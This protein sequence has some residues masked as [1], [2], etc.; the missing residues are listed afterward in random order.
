MKI[1]LLFLCSTFLF[2]QSR[3]NGTLQFKR[4]DFAGQ[5]FSRPWPVG[6]VLPVAC[7][8][9]ES[10]FVDNQQIGT[11]LYI[12]RQANVWSEV[13]E[14]SS[15]SGGTVGQAFD[16]GDFAVQKISE[17]EIR[18]GSSCSIEKPCRARF[19]SKVVTLSNFAQV[20][21]SGTLGTGKLYIWLDGTGLRVGHNTQA[22]VI[23]NSSCAVGSNVTDFP[24]SG[25]PLAEIPFTLN[26]F[27]SITPDTDRRAFLGTPALEAGASGNLLVLQNSSTGIAAVDLNPNIDFG[28]LVSTRPTRRGVASQIPA[29]CS[30]GELYYQTD[31]SVGL[32]HCASANVWSLVGGSMQVQN[33]G[34]VVGSQ[35]KINF[36]SG[37]G[38]TWSCANEGGMQRITCLLNLEPSVLNTTFPR[39]AAANVYSAGFL[40]DFSAAQLRVPMEPDAA[41]TSSGLLAFDSNQGRLRVGRNGGPQTL[42]LQDTSVQA[43]TITRPNAG[44]TGTGLNLLAALNGSGEAV[45]PSTSLRSG[46]IGVTI[47]GAGV[48]GDAQIAVLGVAQCVADNNTV[49]GNY[50]VIGSTT[51][52]RCRDAGSVYPVSEQVIGRWLS[53]ANQGSLGNVMLFGLGQ[54]NAASISWMVLGANSA[55]VPATASQYLSPSHSGFDGSHGNRAFA[56]PSAGSAQRISYRTNSTQ[57]ASGALQCTLRINDVDSSLAFTVAGGQTAAAGSATGT[58]T[59]TAGDLLTVRCANAASA[60]SASLS[61]VAV[62]VRL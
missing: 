38:T 51:S 11:K 52:G 28:G 9:G 4:P 29:T 25:L 59:W 44:A 43:L 36:G 49:I 7:R 15:G 35:S 17:T 62:E 16:L 48:S 46:A 10:F 47:G 33:D 6:T 54:Q 55:T 61:S 60:A 37:F 45:L 14:G 32:Y 40:Q 42:A 30:V 12:C 58:A 41:P 31:Q 53:S 5:S 2:G 3:I 22:S 13:G 21:L 34:I 50:V 19:G 20:T 8:V 56:A 1:Y 39:L 23:C 18:I 24:L 27:P 57:P 26:A